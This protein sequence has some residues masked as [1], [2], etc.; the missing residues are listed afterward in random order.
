MSVGWFIA[1]QH[2]VESIEDL[3]LGPPSPRL[4]IFPALTANSFEGRPSARVRLNPDSSE[5]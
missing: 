5:N 4:K 3:I 2:G 1:G